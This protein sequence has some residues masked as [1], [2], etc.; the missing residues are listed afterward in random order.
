MALNVVK[1][2]NKKLIWG[3]DDD[4]GVIAYLSSSRE[5]IRLLKPYDEGSGA[6]EGAGEWATSDDGVVKVGSAKFSVTPGKAVATH[7][8]GMLILAWVTESSSYT[9]ATINYTDV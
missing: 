1:S 8:P 4:V 6:P 9:F 7:V 3:T 2:G 5:I